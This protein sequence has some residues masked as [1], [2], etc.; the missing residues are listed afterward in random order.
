V[1]ELHEYRFR[2]MNTDVAAWLWTDSILAPDRLR[3]V[4][5]FFG[6]VE[7]ELSRFRPSSGLSRLNAEAGNG[8]RPV[9]PLLQT[10]LAAA[11]REAQA[12]GGIFDPTMLNAL[13][14]AGY[15]RS[16][17]LINGA[18]VG[19]A[20][21]PSQ[22][23]AHPS[24]DRLRPQSRGADPRAGPAIGWG[25]VGLDF[26]EGT[27]ALPKGLG[28]DLGGI[29]KGW[30]VDRAAVMLAGQGIGEEAEDA[31]LVDAGGDIRASAA[32]GGEPWPIA[33]QHPLD[34]ARD[35]GVLRLS[36]GAVAT[37]SVSGRR[38]QQHGRTMH[39]LIDP[40]TREPS[41][42]NLAA[43]TVLAPTTVEAEVAAKVALILGQAEGAAYLKAHSLSG[44]LMDH[45]GSAQV[46]G[47]MHLE[48]QELIRWS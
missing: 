4:E 16:F 18:P 33:I 7:A 20:K 27:V 37:S 34:E 22:G 15:D 41:R 39:H 13:R 43:A 30:A 38:W 42:S 35:L 9:S 2:A 46:I 32:P 5:T 29:A 21:R 45:A 36:S 12:S 44:L 47:E 10:V 28:I 48:K 19:S 17:E 25:Q 8:P 26:A 6:Q 3:E 1:A 24:G 31:A 40:R 11:L 14:Q 23:G